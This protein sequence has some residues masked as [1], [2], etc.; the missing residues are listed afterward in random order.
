MEALLI[1][2]LANGGFTTEALFETELEP[3]IGAEPPPRFKF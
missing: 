3:L 1:T 2:R